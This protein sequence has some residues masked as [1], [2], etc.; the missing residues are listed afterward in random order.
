ME[1]DGRNLTNQLRACIGAMP[2]K[3][4]DYDDDRVNIRYTGKGHDLIIQV[5]PKNSSAKDHLAERC[6]KAMI[7][8]IGDAGMSQVVIEDIKEPEM[9]LE[10]VYIRAKDKNT[11]IARNIMF[12]RFFESLA[13]TFSPKPV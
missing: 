11:D 6:A 12:P 8:T 5:F 9:E 2:V 7:D 10:S 1:L 13:A 3:F 4:D